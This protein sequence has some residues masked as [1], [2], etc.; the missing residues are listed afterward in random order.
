MLSALPQKLKRPPQRLAALPEKLELRRGWRKAWRRIASALVNRTE[1]GLA[2]GIRQHVW[3]PLF[4]P[5]HAGEE[6]GL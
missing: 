1:K 5:E 2:D 4:L 3:G 6:G